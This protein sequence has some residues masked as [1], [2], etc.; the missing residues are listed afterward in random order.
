MKSPQDVINDIRRIRFWIGF[1]YDSAPEDERMRYEDGREFRRDAARIAS[2]IQS[3]KPHFILE[4][5]Q[6]ADDNS[7]SE[8][9][10][11]SVKFRILD[12]LLL[13]QNNEL[14]LEEKDARALCG[15]G[16]TT[17][18]DKRLGY[19]GEKGIGFKSV[20]MI[21]TSPQI[22]SNGYHFSFDYN[23][24]EPTSIIIPNWMESV[25]E[26]VDTAKTNILMPLRQDSTD[27]VVSSVKSIDP[28]LL[29]FLRKL[30]RI[31]IE[32]EDPK[33]H[34]MIERED[35]N[36]VVKI[37]SGRKEQ[38]WKIFKPGTPIKVPDYVSEIKREGVEYTEPKLAFRVNKKGKADAHLKEDL[39][40][41]LPVRSYGF[42]FI[43]QA[44]FLLPSSRED[45][46]KN[47]SPTSWNRWIRDNISDIF[48]DAVEFFKSDSGLKFTWY[49][50]IP[51]PDEID[52]PYFQPVAD[53]VID[54]LSRKECILS[55]SGMWLTP[56]RVIAARDAERKL[57][58]NT[59]LKE[60][61]GKE[62][63]NENIKIQD[64]ALDSLGIVRFGFDH[65]FQFLQRSE[66]FEQRGA[67]WFRQLYTYLASRNLRQ[68]QLDALMDLE[69]VYQNQGLL[70]ST[71]RDTVFFPFTEK[72]YSGLEKDI[73]IVD[74]S[75]LAYDE[76]YEHHMI[77]EFLE[78]LGVRE[79]TP[80]EI[81]EK[82]IL[83]LYESDESSLNWQIKSLDVHLAHLS[84]IKD[85]LE[86]YKKMTADT[87]RNEDPLER[88]KNTILLCTNRK[89]NDAQCY[90]HPGNLFLPN[91]YG[92]ENELELLLK[93][94]IDGSFVSGVYIEKIFKKPVSGRTKKKGKN[95]RSKRMKKSELSKWV[96]FF[97]QL[98]VS[99]GLRL[100]ETTDSYLTWADEYEIRRK[101][102]EHNS[103]KDE[104]DNYDL[105]PLSEI[106]EAIKKEKSKKRSVALLKLLRKEWP[107][108]KR[109]RDLIYRWWYYGK[110]HEA[111]V[112]ST[113]LRQLKIQPWIY[114]DKGDFE[115][116]RNVYL[117]EEGLKSLL[118]KEVHYLPARINNTEMIEFLGIHTKTDNP[119][120]LSRLRII[121]EKGNTGKRDYSNLYEFL[122][123]NFDSS[124]RSAFDREKL[125][126]LP[127]SPNIFYT[128]KEVFWGHVDDLLREHLFAVER[129]YPGLWSFF[130]QKLHVK[131]RPELSDYCLLLSKI[132]KT[133][134]IL[135]K[136]EEQIFSLYTE[137]DA[138]LS[139]L[140]DHSE[141][142]EESWWQDLANGYTFWTDKNEMWKNEENI[143]VP[144]NPE[145]YEIFKDNPRFAFLKMP[146]AFYPKIGNFLAAVNIPYISNS[147]NI[148]LK[149]KSNE[150]PI[151]DFTERIR[152]LAP[153]FISYLYNQEY[154]TFKELKEDG[155]LNDIVNLRVFSVDDLL[156]EYTI[157]GVSILSRKPVF[158]NGDKLY[159]KEDPA[160]CFEYLSIEISKH[161]GHPKGFDDF[162]N[163]IFQMRSKERIIR[164]LDVK[165]IPLVDYSTW[166]IKSHKQK[167]SSDDVVER[168]SEALAENPKPEQTSYK[169]TRNFVNQ[170]GRSVIGAEKQKEGY[171]QRIS[172]NG[173]SNA[174]STGGDPAAKSFAQDETVER[175]SSE[176]SVKSEATGCSESEED[177]EKTDIGENNQ[178]PRRD[179][180]YSDTGSVSGKNNKEEEKKED[181]NLIPPEKVPPRM[182]EFRPEPKTS[183]TR[184][185]S[186]DSNEDYGN[187]SGHPESDSG[188]NY[189]ENKITGKWGEEYTLYCLADFEK[190]QYPDAV[191]E[192]TEKGFTISGGDGVIDEAVWLNKIKDEGVGHDI[193]MRI[194][195]EL[196]FI[197]V[198][199]T[200]D[201][202]KRW[203]PVTSEEWNQMVLYKE[204][205]WICRVYDA[206]T[207]DANIELIKNPYEQFRGGVISAVPVKMK[208]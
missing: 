188:S 115:F 105:F 162:L 132:V 20:F 202:K 23:E 112:D 104:V 171:A 74:K 8:E 98:G 31:E 39:F 193:E 141:I 129:H 86:E 73:K 184:R 140:E 97:L 84:Y 167:G 47:D 177:S 168:E 82:Y 123:R 3:E 93:G 197:E 157:K 110:R 187:N 41:F 62:Y 169:P 165:N 208:I 156:V 12:G 34:I 131:E 183:R 2:N 117:K 38:L 145:L 26:F 99:K 179:E 11:P 27:A 106:I 91:S 191:L 144:D 159:S 174:D 7:Y 35:E 15:I 87:V 55:E 128:I 138:G 150:K 139:S 45:V 69:I 40:N 1:D 29:L 96:N 16:E 13:L 68:D 78:K 147:V 102:G 166:G 25:P 66:M 124:V 196:Y 107:N 44:D 125:I 120:I 10:V 101:Q 63:I 83:P 94:I 43:I 42:R 158:L 201:E 85:H 185:G 18:R 22:H 142:E 118:G 180:D 200:V 79:P 9:A 103:S 5:I 111:R 70:H 36:G 109:Y 149:E 130:V 14:G 137:I 155:R 59:A 143:F 52:D 136:R 100:V 56:D 207:V 154:D 119:A 30:R 90:D 76:R 148:V 134:K 173:V 152:S 116:S 54:K 57:I 71:N 186:S 72:Q 133:E 163:T 108:L 88:L 195:N 33:K 37:K 164:L 122:D 170:G 19:I 114:T 192:N 21:T 176:E 80:F 204:K 189:E 205:Y 51:D 203:F 48:A 4:L 92:N 46:L 182:R 61:F 160:E 53:E 49:D 172:E 81:I 127:G 178:E 60:I 135:P 50:Y 65:I 89:T 28:S 67:A 190:T 24:R 161:L 181:K 146:G 75:I 77:K 95:Q 126:Y 198:K 17:K 121:C 58:S 153:Y 64:R 6:N 113:W 151:P 199:S 194:G 175:S 206:L 32:N